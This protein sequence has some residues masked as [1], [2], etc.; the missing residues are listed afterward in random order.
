MEESKHQR[1]TKEIKQKRSFEER[2]EEK[3][4]IIGVPKAHVIKPIET[5][6]G[7]VNNSSEEWRENQMPMVESEYPL[8][9]PESK[10]KI[11]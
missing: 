11:G 4:V 5:F 8:D 3:R 2:V 10:T 7:K 9:C 6:I 1:E